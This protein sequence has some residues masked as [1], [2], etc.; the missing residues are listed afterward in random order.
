MNRKK[1]FPTPF[2]VCS[3]AVILCAV[4]LAVFSVLALSS[5][6]ANRRLSEVSA[7]SIRARAEAELEADRILALIRSGEPPEGVKAEEN[8]YSFTVDCDGVSALSVK[9]DTNGSIILWQL[10]R[11]AEWE[12][13][14]GLEL[15]DPG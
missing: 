2:G 15:S 6:S 13:D 3:V 11:T 4:A 9:V 7:Q 14:E 5:A 12:A 1:V 10:I 8:G